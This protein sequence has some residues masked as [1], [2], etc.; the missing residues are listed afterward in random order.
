MGPHTFPVHSSPLKDSGKTYMLTQHTKIQASKLISVK[1]L[2][3][4]TG[5]GEDFPTQSKTDAKNSVL[6]KE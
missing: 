4:I 2:K 1:T 6:K 3:I 5:E